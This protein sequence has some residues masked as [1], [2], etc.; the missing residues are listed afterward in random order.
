[1]LKQ[2][3]DK[4]IVQYHDDGFFFPINAIPMEEACIARSQLEAFE[5][6]QGHPIGGVQQNKSRLLFAWVDA[7]IR[8][9]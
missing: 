8:T 4:A 3:R 6:G 5:N 1:M 7:L 2:L 9:P